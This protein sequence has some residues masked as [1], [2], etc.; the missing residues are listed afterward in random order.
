MYRH[1][2]TPAIPTAAGILVIAIFA[3]DKSWNKSQ[4]TDNERYQRHDS[5]V[6]RNTLPL[7]ITVSFIF[8]NDIFN[9]FFRLIEQPVREEVKNQWTLLFFSFRSCLSGSVFTYLFRSF[10][11]ESSLSLQWKKIEMVRMP[12]LCFNWCLLLRWW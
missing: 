4:V 7:V 10:F 6:E 2:F 5:E 3:N 11:V 9:G 8:F 1:F 12:N